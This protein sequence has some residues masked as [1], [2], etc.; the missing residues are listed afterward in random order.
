M[1]FQSIRAPVRHAV[2][3]GWLW[4]Y[5][6][7]T[8]KRT[9]VEWS[10]PMHLLLCV[11]DHYEP[12]W[13][14]VSAAQ[15]AQRVERWVTEYPRCFADFRD[16]DG[17]PPR[18]TFFYPMEDYHADHIEQLSE[19]C[20]AGYGE[21]EIHLHHDHDTADNLRDRLWEYK[22]IL[23]EDHAQLA[24][25]RHT[26]EIRYAFI[27]GNWALDNARPDGRWCGVNN[28][29]DILRDT[30]CYADLTLPS[31]PSPT[32]TRKINSIY[33]AVDDP[34]R[35]KSHDWGTD[36]G[37]HPPPRRGLLLIQ[38]PLLLNWRRRKWGLLPTVENA[39]LQGNQP[40]SWERLRLWLQARVQ[41]PT[42]PDWFFVK[43]HTH[44]APEKNQ[45]VLLG[46]SMIRFHQSLAETARHNPLFHYHYVTAREMYNLAKAAE[47]GW[48][49]DV[50]E[51]RDYSL[52]WQT[53]DADYSWLPRA[54]SLEAATRSVPFI[55]RVAP[56]G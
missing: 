45:Q 47:M 25:D 22:H 15:A 53:G 52:L 40:P 36:V 37:V 35:P 26:G 46:D 42:R 32:Q 8:R 9:A 13:G 18:H 17:R 2:Q 3:S 10:R 4:T 56:A 20:R 21:I 33:Y 50:A 54:R 51:A 11:A 6:R 49:G 27:H 48:Q 44:G 5:L 30:G 14:H 38:G 19:L 1:L 28:E 34:A 31:F 7:Q 24:R 39:C 23:A 29:L 12:C 41:V 43:L 16:S 55:D